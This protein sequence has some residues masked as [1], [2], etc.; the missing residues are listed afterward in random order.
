M[1]QFFHG[2]RISDAHTAA[3]ALKK[4]VVAPNQL[5]AGVAYSIGAIVMNNYVASYG[6]KCA[7]DV[8]FSISGGLDTRYQQY[9]ERSH[10]TWQSPIAAH[11]R[12]QLLVPKWGRRILSRLGP[13]GLRNFLRVTSVVVRTLKK[14]N[15]VL[16][17]ASRVY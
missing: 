13:D 2:A 12:D 3:A 15:C 16:R 17:S 8:A 7:L 14:V 9:F 4:R 6:K 11:A 5:L 10:R 1:L